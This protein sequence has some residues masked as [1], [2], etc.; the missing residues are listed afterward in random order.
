MERALAALA[1]GPEP[2][3]VDLVLRRRQ[4]LLLVELADPRPAVLANG[5]VCGRRGGNGSALM[6]RRL[7][8]RPRT[9]P[10]WPS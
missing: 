5:A 8:G 3:K 7:I 6:Q 4:Q 1:L 9:D 2:G 10:C